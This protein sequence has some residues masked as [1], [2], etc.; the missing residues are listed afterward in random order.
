MP[1]PNFRIQAFF[2]CD[3]FSNQVLNNLFVN[4]FNFFY[5]RNRKPCPPYAKMNLF[6]MPIM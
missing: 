3:I 1:V 2:I 4:H 6:T 5:L